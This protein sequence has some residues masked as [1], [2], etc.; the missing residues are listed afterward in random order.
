MWATWATFRG[1]CP[2]VVNCKVAGS[3]PA[4]GSWELDTMLQ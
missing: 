1:T 2:T 4:G 3:P